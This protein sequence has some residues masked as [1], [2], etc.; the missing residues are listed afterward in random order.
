MINITDGK[1]F[2]DGE[3][4]A[5]PLDLDA[6]TDY[7]TTVLPVEIPEGHFFVIGD[8]R[9]HSKDSR[10][11]SVGVIDEDEILGKA[12]IRLYPFGDFGLIEHFN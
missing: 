5:E 8:N 7:G 9:N 1:I 12:F 6:I 2:I 10:Y 3:K 4:L 11:S